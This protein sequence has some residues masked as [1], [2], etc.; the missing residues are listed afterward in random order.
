MPGDWSEYIPQSERE[1]IE[2]RRRRQRWLTTLRERRVLIG[3]C[4]GVYLLWCL[5]LLLRGMVFAFS[6]SVLPIVSLPPL[7]YLAW[8]LV[9][10]EFN[11]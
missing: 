7:G 4:V 8:W 1:R 5:V 9:W 10:K 6:L 11:Q 2:R 3:L